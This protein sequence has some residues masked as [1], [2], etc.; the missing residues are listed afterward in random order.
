MMQSLPA[1]LGY[2]NIDG[3]ALLPSALSPQP[4][5]LSHH[6]SSFQ[7]EISQHSPN[8]D[9]FHSIL[10]HNILLH[11]PETTTLFQ[12]PNNKTPKSRNPKTKPILSPVLNK[13]P[14]YTER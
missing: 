3:L 9:F 14:S 12:P 1:P 13:K 8:P 7:I 10:L 4:S 2:L 11:K 5:A 6:P